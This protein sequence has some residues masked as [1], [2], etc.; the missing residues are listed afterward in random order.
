MLV[1][2]DDEP[3][4]GVMS[5]TMLISTTAPVE[6]RMRNEITGAIGSSTDGAVPE[7]TKSTPVETVTKAGVKGT[8]NKVTMLF[9]VIVWYTTVASI[10]NGWPAMIR[11]GMTK[12]VRDRLLLAELVDEA[13]GRT[14]DGAIGGDGVGPEGMGVVVGRDDDNAND[15]DDGAEI[16][17]MLSVTMMV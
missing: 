9:P 3:T 2:N 7:N 11:I 16:D 10:V 1:D 8:S 17:A 4:A 12:G 6:S 5:S 13:M 14:L 15:D